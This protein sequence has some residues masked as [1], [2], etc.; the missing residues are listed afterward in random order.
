[1][2]TDELLLDQAARYPELQCLDC[3][4][5]L[6]QAEW[7]CGH[8]IANE[9]G[10]RA[11]L[12]R[13][14][15]STPA[16]ASLPLVERLGDDFVRVHIAAAKGQGLLPDT[17]FAL[18]LRATKVIS[19][20]EAHFSDALNRIAALAQAGK[21]PFTDVDD[22][23]RAY[24]EAGCPST[25]HS[26]A[27]RAHYAPAYR[28]LDAETARLLPVFLRI[29]RLMA[30]KPRVLVAID[31]PAASGKTT[32]AR[33]LRDVYGASVI[34]M[35]VFFLQPHQRTPERFAT[36]GGNVD[37]ERFLAEVLTPLT[38]HQPVCYRPFDCGKWA[39]GDEVSVPDARLTVI[40]GSYCLHPT[41]ESG[42]D[43]RILTGI[44]PETQR[45]R[46][47]RRNG[48]GMLQRF[49]SEWIPMENA[50]FTAT[51]IETRADI[52]LTNS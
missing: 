42:Y 27:F 24:R 8:L 3:I 43:I 15:D 34:P 12:Q 48:E 47:L 2:T 4:K 32:L 49:V 39:L 37:H 38:T 29:D 23:L 30:Q 6:Y 14:W 9:Q 20:N 17:L 36:P 1:M 46:I 26:E 21:L 41:L 44:D 28:V 19:G 5:A 7:G 52:R 18:F 22:V 40:E 25:H 13:E 11:Y 35:D 16:D 51:H 33:L 45:E 31:G 50:Y 10:A